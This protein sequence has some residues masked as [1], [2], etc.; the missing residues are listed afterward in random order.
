MYNTDTDIKS[1]EEL[2]E[3]VKQWR[4]EYPNDELGLVRYRVV[5]D[6]EYNDVAYEM[7]DLQVFQVGV[8]VES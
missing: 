2:L 6:Y 1:D 4:K 5:K 3:M 8:P 7:E